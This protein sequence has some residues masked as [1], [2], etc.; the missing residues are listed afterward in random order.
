MKSL[1]SVRS[2]IDNHCKLVDWMAWV[3]VV[4]LFASIAILMLWWLLLGRAWMFMA[5]CCILYPN[6]AV[7][8]AWGIIRS[9]GM[10]IDREIEIRR[11]KR[12]KADVKMYANMEKLSKQTSYNITPNL[13]RML[14][15]AQSDN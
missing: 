8:A 14:E 12:A 13:Y 11:E 4:S 5:C 1:K 6:V 7:N 15:L 3:S 2:Q 10:A 9:R